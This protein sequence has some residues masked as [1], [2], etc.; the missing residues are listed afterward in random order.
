MGDE[1]ND[2][3]R[4]ATRQVLSAGTVAIVAA[5]TAA[6]TYTEPNP[7]PTTTS[8]SSSIQS[9]TSAPS[10]SMVSEVAGQIGFSSYDLPVTYTTVG[11]DTW[12][13]IAAAFEVKETT[14]KTF[15]A[16]K[17][18]A[19]PAAGTIVDLRGRD[20]QRPGASGT[21]GKNASGVPETYVIQAGDNP[22]A[23]AARF[24]IPVR[25]LVADNDLPGKWSLSP[26]STAQFTP[27]TTLI[28]K[29]PS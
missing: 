3:T 12:A 5:A 18:A 21:Y 10:S 17:V 7:S 25:N 9:P 6:C 20:Y 24:G 26:E 16:K 2:F 11:G 13:S 15:Q 27:G 29:N 1:L 4:R 8:I 19:E 14:L 23:V 28:L 22:G